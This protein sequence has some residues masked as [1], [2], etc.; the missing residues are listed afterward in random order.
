MALQ[1]AGSE[2]N[3]KK[4]FQDAGLM[5]EPNAIDFTI[6]RRAVSGELEP[7]Y[8]L[9]HGMTTCVVKVIKICQAML[10]QQVARDSLTS[11]A[12]RYCTARQQRWFLRERPNTPE[13][14]KAVVDEFLGLIFDRFP[15]IIVDY[16]LENPNEHGGYWRRTPLTGDFKSS[17][18][19]FYLNGP[20]TNHMLAAAIIAKG[21]V[22]NREFA[23][24][25]FMFSNT[26][27]HEMAHVFIT[28]LGRGKETTPPNSML[29]T[30]KSSDAVAEA[31]F[32]LEIGMFGGI[33]YYY[34]DPVNATPVDG[35]NTAYIN[36]AS[37]F[38]RIN[39]ET[40]D[41]TVKCDFKFPYEHDPKAETRKLSRPCEDMPED[42]YT[43]PWDYPGWQEALDAPPEL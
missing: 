26:I 4:E 24:F 12:G 39:A 22:E 6:H 25:L 18:Q 17:E 31:G 1:G 5:P 10:R 7:R 41:R 28:Y 23:D 33:V 16:T 2:S 32:D 29:R 40:R 14:L 8:P 3:W 37:R 34:S 9:Q 20:I 13:N 38:Y 21:S 19:Y 43:D 11:I 42:N 36:I 35:C 27:F 30:P 15:T